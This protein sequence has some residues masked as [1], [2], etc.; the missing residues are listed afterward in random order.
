MLKAQCGQWQG[1]ASQ[2]THL[3]TDQRAQAVKDTE[4]TARLEE[5]IAARAMQPGFMEAVGKF[6]AGVQRSWKDRSAV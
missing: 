4:R 1:Q 6:V 3:L 5:A 2:I